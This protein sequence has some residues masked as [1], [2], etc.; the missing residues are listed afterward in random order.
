MGAGAI[1]IYAVSRD[2][3]ILH[4]ATGMRPSADPSANIQ[5]C[6][7]IIFWSISNASPIGINDFRR[8]VPPDHL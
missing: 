8:L 7:T 1:M 5:L 4:R 6:P 3:V 2:S